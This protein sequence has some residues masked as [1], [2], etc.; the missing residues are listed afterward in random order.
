MLLS[1]YKIGLLVLSI[2]SIIALVFLSSGL[3]QLE[4]H[5]GG[6]SASEVTA[7]M[8]Y[9]LAFFKTYRGLFF[10]IILLCGFILFIWSISSKKKTFDQSPPR[11]KY[12]ILVQILLTAVAILLLRRKLIARQLNLMSMDM[13][14][15]SVISSNDAVE[16]IAE[17]IPNWLPF[18]VSL[19]LVLLACYFLWLIYRRSR[20]PK[21]KLESITREAKKALES[22][23][24]KNDLRGVILRC[25]YQ[26]SQIMREERGIQRKSSMTPREFEF[27]LLNIGLP[28]KPVQ[29]LTALFEAVRY[30]EKELG[31]KAEQLAISCLRDIVRFN[32]EKQ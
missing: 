23:E 32:E 22:I 2:V 29:Q 26:M 16:F 21:A 17:P 20:K 12:I 13:V 7:E 28:Q 14:S 30:G 24:H 1:R 11:G 10:A 9:L 5:Q 31:E 25:Y 18:I 8:Q 15:N 19:M 4:F 6:L 3:T 27:H